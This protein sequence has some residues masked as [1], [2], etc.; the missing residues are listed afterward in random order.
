MK[1]QNWRWIDW[2]R[3]SKSD[4]GFLIW[5]ASWKTTPLSLGFTHQSI[6]ISLKSEAPAEKLV[7]SLAQSANTLNLGIYISRQGQKPIS[8]LTGTTQRKLSTLVP[9]S[10][11]RALW[12][13]QTGKECAYLGVS[14]TW[15]WLAWAPRG[16]EGCPRFPALGQSWLWVWWGGT[17]EQGIL[18]RTVEISFNIHKKSLTEHLEVNSPKHEFWQ[19]KSPLLSVMF[20]PLFFEYIQWQELACFQDN[21]IQTLSIIAL[22]EASCHFLPLKKLAIWWAKCQK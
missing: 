17:P 4:S 8:Y 9:V 1:N 16:A 22:K 7:S 3:S 20:P 13:W 10:W 14:A 15:T 18:N 12:C 2:Y 6:S 5:I 21:K 11:F 19:G